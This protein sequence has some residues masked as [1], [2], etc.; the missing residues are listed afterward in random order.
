MAKNKVVFT[1]E[2]NKV[3]PVV[4][5]EFMQMVKMKR[6]GKVFNSKRDYTRK[7]KHRKNWLDY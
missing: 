7:E 6:N 4:P 3:N 2:L 5:V 1:I